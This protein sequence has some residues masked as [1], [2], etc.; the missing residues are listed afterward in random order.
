MRIAEAYIIVPL[1]EQQ[2]PPFYGEQLRLLLLGF[3]RPELKFS[4]IQALIDEI[5]SDVAIGTSLCQKSLKPQ[6]QLQSQSSEQIGITD[7]VLNLSFDLNTLSDE[8][9]A[10]SYR[11]HDVELSKLEATPNNYTLWAK[12]INRSSKI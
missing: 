3:I 5:E 8:I 2:L 10:A 1:L 9:S 12:V 4:S 6:A 11:F 7:E